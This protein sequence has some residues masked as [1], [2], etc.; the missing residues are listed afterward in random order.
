METCQLLA[1]YEILNVIHMDRPQ[2]LHFYAWYVHAGVLEA[3]KIA[4]IG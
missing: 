2:C 3:Q 1:V 4:V